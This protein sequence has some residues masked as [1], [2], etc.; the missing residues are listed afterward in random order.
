MKLLGYQLDI[1]ILKSNNCIVSVLIFLQ[2]HNAARSNKASLSLQVLHGSSYSRYNQTV[3]LAKGNICNKL[4][5]YFYYYLL[6]NNFNVVQVSLVAVACL[7]SALSG[8][9]WSRSLGLTHGHRLLGQ[10]VR[11]HV[12]RGQERHEGDG[13]SPGEGGGDSDQYH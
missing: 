5:D 2:L 4:F 9:W 7:W 1:G 11:L 12:G 10:E 13:G 6:L 8:L 3:R